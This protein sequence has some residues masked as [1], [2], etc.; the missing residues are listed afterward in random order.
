MIVRAPA[1]RMVLA[2][3]AFG[4]LVGGA[5]G[6]G[7]RAVGA[8]AP[9]GLLL[10]A[11]V[12]QDGASTRLLDPTHRLDHAFAQHRPA[13]DAVWSPDGEHIAYLSPERGGIDIF[14]FSLATFATERVTE[15]V[16]IEGGA[17]WSPDGRSLAFTAAPGLFYTLYVYSFET[18]Q[19]RL[20]AGDGVPGEPAARSRGFDHYAPAWSADGRWIAF[21][22]SAQGWT[23]SLWAARADGSSV[24]RLADDAVNLSDLA[25]AADGCCILY[26]RARP[27]SPPETRSLAAVELETGRVHVLD[28]VRYAA[29]PAVA[30]DGR[31]MAFT[32]EPA[33]TD[34]AQLA[35]VSIGGLTTELLMGEWRGRAGFGPIARLGIPSNVYTSADWSADGRWLAYDWSAAGE[36]GIYRVEAGVPGAQ[37]ERL[38][39]SALDLAP[40]WQPGR[41]G[42]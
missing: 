10:Y 42:G 25:W 27:N 15:T 38:T 12:D 41:A 4:L 32:G 19:T 5:A 7:A 33:P 29:L 2:A 26:E 28:G 24:R 37:P 9:P 20:L 6:V 23:G 34:G 8:A 39:T 16:A 40:R 21:R 22:T 11:T 3:A 31:R 36:S 17:A 1:G 35:P 13:F 18:G 14:T 30:R